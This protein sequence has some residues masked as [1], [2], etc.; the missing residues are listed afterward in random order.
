M[1]LSTGGA[2]AEQWRLGLELIGAGDTGNLQVI[3]VYHPQP[4]GQVYVKGGLGAAMG[5][6]WETGLGATTEV[7]YDLP[8]GSNW[9]RLGVNAGL[10]LQ[11]FGRAVDGRTTTRVLMLGIHGF[12]W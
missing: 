10:L 11:W 2:V 8:L 12:L 7:G 9:G 3:T 1:A 5:P 6:R 4:M